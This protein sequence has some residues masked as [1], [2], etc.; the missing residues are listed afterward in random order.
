MR[1]VDFNVSSWVGILGFLVSYS[2]VLI[3]VLDGD[4]AGQIAYFIFFLTVLLVFLYIPF[5]RR[6]R[7]WR[8]AVSEGNL[9]KLEEALSD[10][11]AY[12]LMDSKELR[13]HASRRVQDSGNHQV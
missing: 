10:L 4:R 1:D 3:R 5:I 13:Y 11:T 12:Y 2:N 7:K 6:R 8:T 9:H